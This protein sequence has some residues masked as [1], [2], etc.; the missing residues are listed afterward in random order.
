MK[1]QE[2]KRIVNPQDIAYR[3]LGTPN[4]TGKKMWYKAPWRD[5]K[6]ASLLVDNRGFYDFGES[7]GRR[8]I[9][10]YAKIF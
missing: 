8:Y 6:T 5:E 4:K 9:C 3:Y 1:A 7:W 2:I 10:I